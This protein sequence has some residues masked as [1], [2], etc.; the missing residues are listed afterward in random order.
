MRLLREYIRAVL[1]TE[2]AMGPG[3]LPD[4]VV[5]VILREMSD[6]VDIFY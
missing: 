4:D 6:I 3:D 1:L 5:V 2:A